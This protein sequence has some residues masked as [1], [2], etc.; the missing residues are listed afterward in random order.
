[1]LPST[2]NTRVYYAIDKTLKLCYDERRTLLVVTQLH[3]PQGRYYVHCS[4]IAQKRR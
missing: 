1:M 3:L 4:D 2:G